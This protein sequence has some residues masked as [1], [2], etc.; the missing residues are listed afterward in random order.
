MLS[1]GGDKMGLVYTLKVYPQGRG[2]SVYRII[3]ISERE[4]LNKL[5]EVILDSFDFDNDHLFEFCMD[6][7]M[8][9]RN[10]YQ[11]NPEGGEPST[12]VK[13]GKIGLMVKQKFSLHYDFGDDWMFIITVQNIQEDSETIKSHVVKE[14]GTIEQYPEWDDDWDDE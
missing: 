1:S 3:K 4:T 8:Y 2:T 12:R 6:N 10:S 7:K 14:K 5:C 13:I 11:S 9:S